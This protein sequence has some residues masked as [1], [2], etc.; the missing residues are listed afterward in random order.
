[1]TGL[2]T[3][4]QYDPAVASEQTF[5]A[6]QADDLNAFL[7]RC[8]FKYQHGTR[9]FKPYPPQGIPL[10]RLRE[11]FQIIPACIQSAASLE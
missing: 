10:P 8:G 5:I 6:M 11:N 4:G 9:R 7:A 1:M 2:G 3:A